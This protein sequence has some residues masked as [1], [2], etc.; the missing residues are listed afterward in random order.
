LKYALVLFLLLPALASADTSTDRDATAFVGGG[1]TMGQDTLNLGDG[2]ATAKYQDQ[3]Y[4]VEGGFSLPMGNRFGLQVSAELGASNAINTLTSQSYMETGTLDFYAGK[5]G[6]FFGPLTIG[7]GYRHNDVDIKSL[8]T[9][10]PGYLES[11]Y[12]GWTSLAFANL[13]M[14]IRKRYRAVIETQYDSGTLSGT[15]SSSGTVKFSE[16]SVSL[17]IFFLFD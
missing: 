10:T 11:N 12:S 3:G 8:S 6:L 9:P 15:G 16:M 14:D 17:R 7:G 4:V 2:S 13:S 5:A 1:L